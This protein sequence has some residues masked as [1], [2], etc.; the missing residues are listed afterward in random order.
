MDDN[1]NIEYEKNNKNNNHVET[2][3]SSDSLD[4]VTKDEFYGKENKW[5]KW[6]GMI[7]FIIVCLVMG[8]LLLQFSSIKIE[9][10]K[11][12]T[13]KESMSNEESKTTEITYGEEKNVS[14][15]NSKYGALYLYLEN[16]EP[17]VVR[18]LSNSGLNQYLGMY[19][20]ESSNCSLC[21]TKFYSKENNTI[22]IKDNNKCFLYN[23][24]NNKI[25]TNSYAN[26][27]VLSLKNRK[28]LLGSSYE[29]NN[30]YSALGIN[31]TN[32]KYK[33]L[34]KIIDNNV[35]RYL[36]NHIVFEENNKFG[37]LDYTNNKKVIEN[38]YNDIRLFDNNKFGIK[39]ENK[40]YLINEKEEKILTTGYKEIINVV[41]KYIFVIN[42]EN[43]DIVDY[44]GKSLLKEQIKLSN[45]YK[46]QDNKEL[47]NI[48]IKEEKEEVVIAINML[49][50]TLNK[51]TGVILIDNK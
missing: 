49:K 50:Y 15:F 11:I 16:D 17:K 4:F 20:C 43:F 29:K 2:E 45:E 9:G 6:V 14:D 22:L 42:E 18:E 46:Y 5:F 3:P 30:I 33:N 10:I 19:N 27:Y 8:F 37:I 39:K 25:L 48:Q 1:K 12:N 40:W 47:E 36:N 26:F 51:Q 28:Y 44:D 21:D 34:G 41:D 23:F 24:K 35:Y 7:I 32:D 31:L 13:P 38:K